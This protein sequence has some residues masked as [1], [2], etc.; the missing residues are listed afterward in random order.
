MWRLLSVDHFEADQAHRLRSWLPGSYQL[1]RLGAVPGAA[2]LRERA[3]L[4]LPAD[5]WNATSK[6][7]TEDV[8]PV[9]KGSG[10]R[11]PPCWTHTSV[12]PL[13][14]KWPLMQGNCLAGARRVRSQAK[15]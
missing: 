10:P 1:D 12:W 15:G 3:G 7:G 14:T 6:K 2:G 11:W 5:E 8:L 9:S 13:G 4:L